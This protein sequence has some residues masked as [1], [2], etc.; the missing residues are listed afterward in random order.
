MAKIISH[1]NKKYPT[2]YQFEENGE[3]YMLGSEVGSYLGYYKGRLYKKFPSLWRKILDYNERRTL[4]NL[5]VKNRILSNMGTMVVRASEA[6]KI[7]NGCGDL[8][9]EKNTE[10][11]EQNN[12]NKAAINAAFCRAAPSSLGEKL[13]QNLTQ[14]PKQGKLAKFHIPKIRTKIVPVHIDFESP[15]STVMNSPVRSFSPQIGTTW[16][17]SSNDE[18]TSHR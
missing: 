7:L 1:G 14:L 3:Q 5:N 8:Y 17:E 18:R 10:V 12:K 4:S 13:R 9:R 2:V 16:T 11:A 6:L 15:E